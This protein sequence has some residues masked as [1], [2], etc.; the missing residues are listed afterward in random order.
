MNNNY[1]KSSLNFAITTRYQPLLQNSKLFPSWIVHNFKKYKIP[2]T[3]D[4][5]KD[6]DGCIQQNKD[7]KSNLRNYQIF[8]SK[9]MDYNS[10][11]NSIL[12]Y[13]G[14]GSD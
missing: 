1:S 2:K 7:E 11:F 3:S 12:L 14:T 9:F 8:L 6:I 13:Y 4:I 5:E 10:P